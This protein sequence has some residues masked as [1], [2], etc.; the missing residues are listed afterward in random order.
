MFFSGS[1]FTSYKNIVT[2]ETQY[3]PVLLHTAAERDSIT[4]NLE[5]HECGTLFVHYSQRC[6]YLRRGSSRV[7]G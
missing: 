5:L 4:C 2:I 3:V 6:A 7:Y 1:E